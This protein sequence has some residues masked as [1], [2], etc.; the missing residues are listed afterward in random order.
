MPSTNLITSSEGGLV[1]REIII[2]KL[3]LISIPITPIPS[4]EIP[5]TQ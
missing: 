1:K 5:N 2:A 4:G 3:K